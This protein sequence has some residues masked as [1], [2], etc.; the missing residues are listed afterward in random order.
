MRLSNRPGYVRG[1][2]YSTYV[3]NVRNLKR[4]SKFDD[5]EK[6]LLELIDATERESKAE[7]SGVAP[8]YYDELAKIYRK[9]KAYFKEVSI[10]ERFF[11]QKHA[12]GVSPKKL[13]ER[14]EKAKILNTKEKKN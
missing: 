10:L 9:Q 14:L 13:L 4:Q 2:H 3:G 6:L 7:K 8:W 11:K 5:A 12:P 1:R